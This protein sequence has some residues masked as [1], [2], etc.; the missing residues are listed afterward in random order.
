MTSQALIAAIGRL[1]R[2]MPRNP[3]V[4]EVQE[5]LKADLVAKPVAVT[6]AKAVAATECLICEARRERQRLKM[7]RY[8]G[9]A[10]AHP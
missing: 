1:V 10:H 8:R 7:K 5:A 9:K 4:I 6:Q 3:A 2:E